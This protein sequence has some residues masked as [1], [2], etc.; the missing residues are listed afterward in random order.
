MYNAFTLS[1]LLRLPLRVLLPRRRARR[2]R[3]M[4]LLVLLSITFLVLF[5]LY[6]LYKPPT[7][8]I[9]Y[10]QTK[11][12]SVTFHIAD[13]PSPEEK[14]VALTIDDGPSDYTLEIA[15]LLKEHEAEA[16]FFVLG[17]QIEGREDVLRKLIDGGNELGNHAMNDVPARDLPEAQLKKEII[18]VEAKLRELYLTTPGFHPPTP[19]RYYRPGSGF[20]TKPMLSTIKKLA[21][22]PVLGS[23]Y[24]YDAQIPYAWINAR[25]ILSM[26]KPGEIIICH[27]RR[28]WTIPMLKT[29]L[30]EMK[31]RGY[32]ITT[33]SSMGAIAEEGRARNMAKEREKEREKEKE[34]DTGKGT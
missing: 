5:P 33:V 22:V 28:P 24:P 31:R 8:L 16:T 3:A 14:V 18:A 6:T 27:D 9:D 25:H 11:Y 12:P 20:F 23:I 17:S 15:S 21:Y 32:K 2:T 26:L 10:F 4:T 30:P 1:H 34:K 13:W 19:P 29:I 7:W